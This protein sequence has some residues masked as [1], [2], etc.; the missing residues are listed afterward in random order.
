[1][2]SIDSW[3]RFALTEVFAVLLLVFVYRRPLREGK[4][5]IWLKLVLSMLA[6][7]MAHLFYAVLSPAYFYRRFEFTTERLNLIPFRALLSTV[8]SLSV[9]RYCRFSLAMRS[10]FLV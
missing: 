8:Y 9:L 5:T 4:A 7:Y 1:M 10:L 6:M 3:W 2:L